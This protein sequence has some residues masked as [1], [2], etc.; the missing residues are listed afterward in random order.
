VQEE[1]EGGGKGKVVGGSPA[2]EVGEAD[3]PAAAALAA[4]AGQFLQAHTAEGAADAVIGDD[5]DVAAGG[6]GDGPGIV[7]DLRG[8]DDEALQREWGRCAGIARRSIA[9][10]EG[11]R[12]DWSLLFSGTNG[13]NGTN[14]TAAECLD[15]EGGQVAGLEAWPLALVVDG[16]GFHTVPQPG[17]GGGLAGVGG[18]VGA[19]VRLRFGDATE[20]A[21][22]IVV[23]EPAGD[24][25]N[26][27][28]GL[29]AAASEAGLPG[30]SALVGAKLG[31]VGHRQ[32]PQVIDQ[33]AA[34]VG[35]GLLVQRVG[36]GAEAIR[37]ADEGD[38]NGAAG[39]DV[40]WEVDGGKEAGAEGVDVT[41]APGAVG[42]QLLHSDGTAAAIAGE[43]QGAL[44]GIG[45]AGVGEIL[46]II[47]GKGGAILGEIAQAG[48]AA[49]GEDDLAEV[50]EL[51]DRVEEDRLAGAALAAGPQI[52]DDVEGV[53]EPG[54]EDVAGD[55]L[56]DS[57]LLGDRSIE[58][59]EAADDIDDAV[60]DLGGMGAVPGAVGLDAMGGPG[61]G[62]VGDLRQD[63]L[64]AELI[65]RTVAAGAKEAA[66]VADDEEAQAG[67][68]EGRVVLDDVTG[69]IKGLGRGDAD[70]EPG[71]GI[72]AAI[73]EGEGPAHDGGRGIEDLDG[74]RGGVVRG[75]G[76]GGGG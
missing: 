44:V 67:L 10:R 49:A 18:R 31:Q 71:G 23:I 60:E 40:I 15:D 26:G 5:V 9:L 3:F 55:H 75:G 2:G 41:G 72:G 50:G 27:A 16:E 57:A 74:G 59:D 51:G 42:T 65:E 68:D 1:A 22:L 6:V 13:P 61:A 20:N 38:D 62:G 58:I 39:E 17:R 24:G 4:G 11:G 19:L 35:P 14:G 63:D 47:E 46:G 73:D 34:I 12:S 30:Y 52:A 66:I 76:I 53:E 33:R 64:E 70:V 28:P 43:E 54:G 7:D 56:G 36:V 45:L 29:E 69:P 37:S 21:L 25:E 32:R 48:V 8:G